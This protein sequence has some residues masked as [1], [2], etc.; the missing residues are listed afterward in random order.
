[1]TQAGGGQ[2]QVRGTPQP[3][4]PTI[5]VQGVDTPNP[6]FR[7][8]QSGQEIN[9]PD[10]TEER[11][12]EVRNAQNVTFEAIA[13][14][15]R[16]RAEARIS[17]LKAKGFSQEGQKLGMLASNVTNLIGTI[18]ERRAEIQARKEEARQNRLETIR[19]E[20]ENTARATL[21]QEIG[22]FRR[23][24]RNNGLQKGVERFRREGQEV[25]DEFRGE[26]SPEQFQELQG[27]FHD[28]LNE[29]DQNQTQ[30]R[31]ESLEQQKDTQEAIATEQV[32][33]ELSANI[34]GIKHSDNPAEL[35][36]RLNE[37]L[38]R[39]SEL[40]RQRSRDPEALSNILLP[41]LEEIKT[42]TT[43]S[44]EAVT[45]SNKKQE[46]ILAYA[47]R[48]QPVYDRYNNGEISGGQLRAKLQ[49]IGADTGMTDLV[50]EIFT[51]KDEQRRETRQRL[52]DVAKIRELATDSQSSISRPQ[53]QEFEDAQVGRIV[54]AFHT[55]DEDVQFQIQQALLSDRNK[56]LGRTFQE[57]IQQ[58]D[59]DEKEFRSLEL[60]T[61]NVLEEQL[62]F[63]LEN[64]EVFFDDFLPQVEYDRDAQRLTLPTKSQA[65]REIAGRTGESVQVIR[66][67][68]KTILKRRNQLLTRMGI[69]KTKWEDKGIN[70][71]D[72][73]DTSGLDSKE[74]SIRPLLEETRRQIPTPR[75]Q[76]P[77]RGGVPNPNSGVTGRPDTPSVTPLAKS[78]DGQFI[79]PFSKDFESQ[80]QVTSPYGSR[81]HPVTGQQGSLHNGVD[82]AG[83]PDGTPVRTIQGGKVIT[84]Q[85]ISGFGLTV[86]VRT[87]D[88]RSEQFSHLQDMDVQVGDEIPAGESIGGL[89]NTGVGTGS[90]LHFQVWK[91][92][93]VWGSRSVQHANTM[94]PTDYLREV[95]PDNAEPRGQGTPP[96]QQF[97][98]GD[99]AQEQ[100]TVD[101]NVD[102]Q[103]TTGNPVTVA[104]EAS[105]L[106]SS[107]PTTADSTSNYGYEALQNDVEFREAIAQT[108]TNTNVPAQWIVDVMAHETAGTFDPAIK[109]RGGGGDT[110]LI[111]FIPSTAK[112]LGTT[113]EELAKMDRVEQMR[114]V[115]KYIETAP[116]PLRTF[117]QFASYI[118]TGQADV[119]A[120]NDSR[121]R[122]LRNYVN[123]IGRHVG[124]K[125]KTLFDRASRSRQ[126]MHTQ[127]V[128]GCSICNT[129]LKNTGRIVSHKANMRR[130]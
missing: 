124:R 59:E 77:Q 100:A 46:Q 96:N 99:S 85:N 75:S 97:E 103:V 113:T 30:R 98:G 108:A 89:G 64:R 101:R 14:S 45:Q 84:A 22:D 79:R 10:I 36:Q 42:S 57:Q 6:R 16:A 127:R 11:F 48:A 107:Y 121:R 17:D 7:Q 53:M 25:L 27:I 2:R 68:L 40:S 43:S 129:M 58:F 115:Q 112:A 123:R 34:A 24:V 73:T 109:N 33:T 54:H 32:L 66:N 116:I 72:L 86:I 71:G 111:Q 128:D 69:L 19:A 38:K 125:Y 119:G 82:Y 120:L 9:L 8:L 37:T 130:A 39:A 26:L 105:N 51:T 44:A 83:V 12:A 94:N 23:E 41:V 52:E 91:A 65:V 126:Q 18:Q 50:G 117:E 114:F 60:E 29:A 3:Q 102:E 47:Q 56:A 5:R 15:N 28:T 67:R 13:R 78:P 74:S 35:R 62:D 122:K 87:P 21:Q 88:G 80:V 95:R 118:F 70:I 61:L 110:G 90:H 31:L 106:R 4:V 76:R 104:R 63:K 1:M 92:D 55:G 81:T 20:K 49:A 93:P